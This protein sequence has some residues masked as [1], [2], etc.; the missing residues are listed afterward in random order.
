MLG[1]EFESK[2]G[3]VFTLRAPVM[4]QARLALH[5]HNN[6]R[7]N[8]LSRK[9]VE[10]MGL[11][12]DLSSNDGSITYI[13]RI[14][15][16]EPSYFMSHFPHLVMG[17]MSLSCVWRPLSSQCMVHGKRYTMVGMAAVLHLCLPIYPRL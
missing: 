1:P 5:K 3:Q 16:R 10:S 12:P 2:L 11:E 4:P 6:A 13:Y 8:S 9:V 14:S 15:D 7:S 17:T